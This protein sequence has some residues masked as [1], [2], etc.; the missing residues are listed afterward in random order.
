M[1]KYEGDAALRVTYPNPAAPH[2]PRVPHIEVKRLEDRHLDW[3]T[4]LCTL[5]LFKKVYTNEFESPG[6]ELVPAGTVA[7]RFRPEDD[8]AVTGLRDH[9]R[10]EV[11]RGAT[12][13]VVANPIQRPQGDAYVAMAKTSPS[14][15][16]QDQ[17]DGLAPLDCYVDDL[18]VPPGFQRRGLG[19]MVLHTAMRF[20]GYEPE[21]KGVVDVFTE[22]P[23][24]N[25][26]AQ[27]AFDVA[28]DA[29]PVAP[30]TFVEA[31]DEHEAVKLMR[32]RLEAATLVDVVSLLE[33]QTPTL[34]KAL[35]TYPFA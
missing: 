10:R 24:F 6:N 21:S 35:A 12:Y 3:F 25:F 4:A 14:W 16:T 32:V 2:D 23:S 33:E 30:K 29:L 28:K 27:T 13:W 1:T 7:R 9:M 8:T 19:S 18:L 17:R 11:G 20:G 31:D 15:A 22:A 5:T 34:R 26:W